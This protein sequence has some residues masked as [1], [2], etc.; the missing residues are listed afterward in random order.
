M[1]EFMF[2]RSST[3]FNMSANPKCTMSLGKNFEPPLIEG[4]GVGHF[5]CNSSEESTKQYLT[6]QR[7]DIK[8]IH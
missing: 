7:V 3:M 8:I 1:Q 6:L 4:L 5:G 2:N